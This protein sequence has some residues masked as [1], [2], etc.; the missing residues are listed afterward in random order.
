MVPTADDLGDFWQGIVDGQLV[1][2]CEG[3]GPRGRYVVC[4]VLDGGRVGG[5]LRRL[6]TAVLVRVLGGEQQ[7]CV[8]LELGIACSTASKWYTQALEKLQLDAR[9]LPLPLIIAA[10]S[11]ALGTPPP[12]A[13]RRATLFHEGSPFV[14]LTIPTPNLAGETLLTRAEREVAVALIEGQSRGEIA[15]QRSTSEQ[16]VACQIRGIFSKLDLRGRCALIKRGLGAGWF[17]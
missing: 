1:Y 14:V 8:A 2:Y 12:V 11:W 4:R 5:A 17:R 6:E 10:Q 9:P 13:A 16:T 3:A 7:K 15:V